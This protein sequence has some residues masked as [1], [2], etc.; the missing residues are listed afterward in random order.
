MTLFGAL[1]FS[2]RPAAAFALIGLFWGAFAAHVPVFKARLGVGDGAFGLLMLG[3]G[4]G[5]VSAMWLAPMLERRLGAAALPV[6]SVLFIAMF[7]MPAAAATP[8]VFFAALL[9]LGMGSGLT[10]V[11]MNTRVAELEAAGG[12][13]LMNA[14]HGVFSLGYAL[15]ALGSGWA[16]EAGIGPVAV[17]AALMLLC[18]PLALFSRPAAG[19]GARV[20]TGP[21]AVAPG[22]PG[23]L[24]PVLLCGAVV[25]IAFMTE[26]TVETW[27]ALH[28]ERTLSGSAA[29]GAAGPAVLG[30]TMAFGRF[31]GQSAAARF[32]DFAVMLGG[33]GLAVLGVVLVAAGQGVTV[34]YLGFAA[35]GLG[36]SVVGPIGLAMVARMAPDDQRAAAISRVAVIGFAGFFVAPVIMGQISERVGLQLA[37]GFFAGLL[38]LVVPLAGAI[39]RRLRAG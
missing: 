32:D 5:L 3:T 25:L 28:I 27:S 23:L 29:Q 22:R 31:S 21:G 26:A 18:L 6:A 35:M 2:R 36:V 8:A 12:K 1:R 33:V 19:V 24:A 34:A 9:V 11:V 16:R 10:D 7:W 17:F 13:P 30:L 38:L 14:N 39:R 20:A 15:A 37:F 4:A